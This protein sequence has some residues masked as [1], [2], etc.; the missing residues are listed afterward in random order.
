MQQTN[1]IINQLNLIQQINE[2]DNDID[3]E[4]I[5]NE[6]SCMLHNVY[7]FE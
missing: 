5:G 6:L 4:E 2:N 1:R 7:R 3:I